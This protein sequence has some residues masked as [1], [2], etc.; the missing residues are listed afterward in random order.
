M[1]RRERIG[2]SG[3]LPVAQ[4]KRQWRRGMR[5]QTWNMPVFRGGAA[6]TQ[7]E[8]QVEKPNAGTMG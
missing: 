7:E 6:P 5:W 2:G 4:R 8:K 3:M 1:L